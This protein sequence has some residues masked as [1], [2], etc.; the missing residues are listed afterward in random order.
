MKIKHVGHSSFVIETEGKTILTDPPEE[1]VGYPIYR[2]PVD[3]VTVSHDHFDHNATQL[4][5]GDFQVIKELTG[6]QVGGITVTGTAAWHDDRQGQDRGSNIIFK[7]E[8][9]GLNLVH[10]GDLGVVLTPEQVQSIGAV[11]ILMVPVGGFYTIDANQAWEVVKQLNPKI[12]IPMHY[13]TPRIDF[14]I[15]PVEDFLAKTSAAVKKAEL[16]IT[17]DTLPAQQEV[18]V[19]EE[20]V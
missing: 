6:A 15:T 4:L 5:T 19:L 13:K 18:V 10:L 1:S 3:L 17:K 9:E 12:V 16:V 14:P 8:A 2:Q 20:I 7:L 11:D